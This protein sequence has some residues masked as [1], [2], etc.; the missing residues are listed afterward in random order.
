MF[1]GYK[2]VGDSCPLSELS[3]GGRIG[4]QRLSGAVLKQ[5]AANEMFHSIYVVQDDT[6]G[7]R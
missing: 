1:L 6:E 5:N 3:P 4:G 7:E 2:L